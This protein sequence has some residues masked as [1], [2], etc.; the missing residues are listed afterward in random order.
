MFCIFGAK[1][2]VIMVATIQLL[3]EEM[4]IARFQK[5]PHF[6]ILR[7]KDHLEDIPMKTEGRK[8]NFFQIVISKGHNVDVMVDNVSF[9]AMEH[10][11]SFMA[12][13]QTLSTN[14]K[15]VESLGVGY[16]LAFTPEFLRVGA[17]N[18]ELFTKF[19]FFNKNYSPIY[20]LKENE[21]HYFQLIETIY[22]Y[23]QEY[24][25]ENIEIIRSYLNILLYESRKSFLNGSIQ[26]QT[27]NKR[28]NEIAFSFENLVINTSNKRIGLSYFSDKLNVSLV[29][30][31]ECV[32]KSTGKT[33]KQIITEYLILEA[34]TLLLHSTQTIDKI[35]ETVGYSS[36]S[37]FT[38]FF[39]KHT[40]VSPT[41]YRKQK[42]IPH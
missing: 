9:S 7:F 15:S 21:A 8:C 14:V 34:Q 31:M 38:L 4:Q 33:A 27:F 11:I 29:Y 18:F 35:A 41:K 5:H 37:N 32:K 39:K 22:T 36:T 42:N 3:L 24:S 26:N 12:P 2:V 40:G 19:P 30:L 10:S 13:L 1:S 25:T 17:T 23:F 16:M 6:H 20:F 28:Y